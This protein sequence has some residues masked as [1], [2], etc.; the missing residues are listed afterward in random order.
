MTEIFQKTRDTKI[1]GTPLCT[2]AVA[3]CENSQFLASCQNFFVKMSI[4]VFAKMLSQ[5]PSSMH[6]NYL[7]EINYRNIIWI[8]GTMLVTKIEIALPKLVAI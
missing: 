3:E 4:K 6:P 5:K 7:V 1:S 8:L 2:A